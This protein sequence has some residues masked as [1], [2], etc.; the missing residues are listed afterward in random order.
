MA[1]MATV[2][3]GGGPEDPV[4]DALAAGEISA[5]E[6][7]GE[8][9]TVLFHGTDAVSAADILTN[10]INMGRAAKLGGGDA[11]W[12]TT[13]SSDAGWFA[14]ANPIGGVPA[15]LSISVPNLVI[16]SLSSSNLLSVQGSVYLFQPGAASILNSAATF[17][18]VR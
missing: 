3:I 18:L 11:F 1:A 12:T 5:A 7:I 17:M 6:G 10:G 4:T 2:V 14:A 8:G 15:T 13:S 16:R 9:A